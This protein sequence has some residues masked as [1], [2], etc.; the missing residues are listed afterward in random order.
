MRLAQTLAD[1]ILAS[2]AESPSPCLVAIC[3]WADTGKSTLARDLAA[4]LLRSGVTADY[5]STDGFMKDRAERNALGI[6][7]Y[8]PR[9]IDIAL[10]ASALDRCVAGEPFAYRPY[11]NRSGTKSEQP[12]AVGPV[13]VLVVEGIHAL[14]PDIVER[15]PLKVF[16]DAD[17]ATLR[18][19]RRHANMRKRGMAPEEAGTRI[20]REWEDFSS[21]VLPRKALADLIVRVSRAYEFSAPTVQAKPGNR[22]SANA[23]EVG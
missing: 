6:T 10:L 1:H 22:S 15:F 13:Q 9:S 16:I 3:G 18:Q 4:A 5:I 23:R 20:Q 19:L 21:L 8:D 14:H 17:E 2:I 12:R 11:D 7:G